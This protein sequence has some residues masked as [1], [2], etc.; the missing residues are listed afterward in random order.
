MQRFMTRGLAAI[1]IMLIGT[2][3]AVAQGAY[4]IRSGDT[5]QLEVLEDSSLNR[6]MLVLPDGS[7]SVP[8]VGQI[9]A[10]GR[11]LPEVR[12]DLVAG[13]APNFA[14]G[15]TVFLSVNKVAQATRTRSRD[16]SVYL[17]GEV[18][19]PGKLDVR[20][21]TTLL[22][23]LAESGGLTNFASTKRIQ[24]HRNDG[25]GQRTAYRFNYNA[26]ASG[27]GSNGVAVT[28]RPGDVIIVPAR[29]L[30]E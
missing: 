10:A 15:P 8:L 11:T 13:L 14:S 12:S 4:N 25:T 27:T 23:A 28:L 22:Q 3:S 29:R 1:I 20:R 16:I 17:M 7:V 2:I 19:N 9:R 21:G 6:S 18:N 26:V 24:L 5:L 30:F